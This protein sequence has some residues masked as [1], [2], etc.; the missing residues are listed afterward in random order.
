MAIDTQLTD[1]MPD[2]VTIAPYA[3]YNSYGE[4]TYSGSTRTAKAYVEPAVN[5]MRSDQVQQETRPLRATI[6]DTS[7][8][9][10]DKITLPDS[11]TPEI[12]SIQVHT[13]VTGLEHT[14]VEFK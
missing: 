1:F 14:V 2:T 8:T 11:S 7:I 6:A 3:S 10:R 9:V 4:E 13:N 12:A 5:L